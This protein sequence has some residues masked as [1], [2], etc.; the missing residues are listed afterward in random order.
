V[1]DRVTELLMKA[2]R[3]LSQQEQD[4]VLAGLLAGVGQLRPA[5]PLVQEPWPSAMSSASAARIEIVERL[6]HAEQSATA[7]SAGSAGSAGGDLKVLPVR[8]PS[9][10]YERLRDWSREHGFSMAVII[11]TLVERFIRDQQR[12]GPEQ[13]PASGPG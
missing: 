8:L 2:V 13:N 9:A 4:E 11:R 6:A 10:D 12:R 1:A 7:G 5:H 3:G